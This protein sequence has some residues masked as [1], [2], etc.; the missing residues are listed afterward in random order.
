MEVD[1]VMEV[2]VGEEEDGDLIRWGFNPNHL[3]LN[4]IWQRTGILSYL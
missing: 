2:D 4:L 1:A 3:I